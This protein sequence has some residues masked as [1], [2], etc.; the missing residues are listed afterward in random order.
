MSKIQKIFFGI[1]IGLVAGFIIGGV[2]ASP[3]AEGMPSILLIVLFFAMIMFS[4]G[5]YTGDI[6]FRKKII[7]T[8][9][10]EWTDEQHIRWIFN[11]LK[12]VHNNDFEWA[13][14]KIM[15]VDLQWAYDRM[16]DVHGENVNYDYMI[17]LN[18]I[19]N[20]KKYGK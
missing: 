16:C 19:I 4:I 3:I 17:R 9:K 10:G 2:A 8:T 20:K 11:R 14:E 1:H 6:T 15:V 12:H 5:V 18:K 7:T 13:Y